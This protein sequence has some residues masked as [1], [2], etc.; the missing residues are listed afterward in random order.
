METLMIINFLNYQ[1][2]FN[3]KLNKLNE[4]Y[5]F[6]IHLISCS[7][8]KFFSSKLTLFCMLGVNLVVTFQ[9]EV[10]I[11]KRLRTADL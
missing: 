2:L 11:K 1:L 8:I 9:K 5:D 3:L 6:Y 4:I 10:N 7:K